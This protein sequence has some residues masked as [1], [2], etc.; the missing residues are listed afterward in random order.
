ML[1][2]LTLGDGQN[3]LKNKSNLATAITYPGELAHSTRKRRTR[4]SQYGPEDPIATH[5]HQE[6]HCQPYPV[7]KDYRSESVPLEKLNCFG[8]VTGVLRS[9]K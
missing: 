6:K 5:L 8:I 4:S 1:V 7:N 3:F 9:A 2:L